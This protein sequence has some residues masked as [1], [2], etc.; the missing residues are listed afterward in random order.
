M[1]YTV[2]ILEVKESTYNEIADKLKAAGYD[3]AFWE[4]EMIDMTHI[5]LRKKHENN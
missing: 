5:A 1:T 4:D 2:V 3:H